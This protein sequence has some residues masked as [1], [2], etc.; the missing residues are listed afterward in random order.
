MPVRSR[1]IRNV[2]A[3]FVLAGLMLNVVLVLLALK[4]QWLYGDEAGD[5]LLV[6]L[7]T[8]A[9][10]LS[11]IV[12]TMLAQGSEIAREWASP[13]QES[14]ASAV[15]AI[16]LCLFWLSM[17]SFP[18]LAGVVFRSDEFIRI[19]VTWREFTDLLADVS[20]VA[21]VGYYFNRGHGKSD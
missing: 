17:V 14:T 15:F 10:P 19:S 7:N 20:I 12:A 3:G 6:L 1:T 18:W 13:R 2:I 8:F 5:A 11:L 21:V 16:V 9:V 4:R